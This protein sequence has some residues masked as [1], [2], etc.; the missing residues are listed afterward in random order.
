M[1][2]TGRGAADQWHVERIG[3]ITGFLLRGYLEKACEIRYPF[4]HRPLVELALAMPWSLKAVPGEPKA[5]LRRAMRGILPEPV[6]RRTR[7]ASTG[8]AVYTGLRKEWPVIE[9]ILDS[10]ALVDLGAVDRDRLRNALQLARQGHAPDLGGLLSTLTLD[11]WL[12]DAV[13]RRHAR[14][15][16]DAA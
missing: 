10:S 11:A 7:N 13:R 14:T 2:R 8:H 6:R 16:A 9:R 12:Q 3:W 4:L 5:V 15:N 1:P